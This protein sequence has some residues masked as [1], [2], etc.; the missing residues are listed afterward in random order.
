MNQELLYQI[1]L[2]QIPNIGSVQAKILIEHFGDISAIFKVKESSLKKIEG[3]GEIRA[4][5]IK[6]F[7]DFSKAEIE[8]EFIIKFKIK[9]LFITD[10]DYPKRLLNCY[11]SPTLLFY[12]GSADLNTSKVVAVI[13]TR[14]HTEYAR[15]LTDKFINEISE[16]NVL[17]ISG[18][19]FG[20]DALAHKAALKN[21]L[22]TVGVLAH[23]LDQIY[24]NEH[25]GLAK[26]M[27]KYGG[28]LLTEFRSNTKPDK[29]NFPIRNRIVAGMSDAVIVVET[30]IKGG[31]MIT[32][33]LANGY[34]KDVFAFPGKV[35]DLKSAGCN[36]LI[37]NNKAIL[38]T[39]ATDFIQSMGWEEKKKTSLKKQK[40]L[41]IELT[42]DE[43]KVI[44][45]LQEKETVHIDEINFRSGL[46][47]SAV[48]A[49][50]LNLELKNAIKSLPGK[51]YTFQ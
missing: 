3:I 31:S 33:E 35:N 24:P 43:K 10:K 12:K 18:L 25:T 17:I 46:S 32:A 48:A 36:F 42:E 50:I 13:G 4:H 11:D 30:D 2:T 7:T 49:A 45:I 26:D 8:I 16:Q 29:H 39:K 19:A 37:R 14:N 9:P 20:V 28:G 34:N 38:I 15:Q 41:F 51:I 22:Q 1:A 21:N 5:S 44:K 6:S 27:I 40:E 23:G 47:S